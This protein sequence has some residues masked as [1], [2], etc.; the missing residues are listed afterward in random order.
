[1]GILYF[2]VVQVFEGTSKAQQQIKVKGL[3]VAG[4]DARQRWLGRLSRTLVSLA[5]LLQG[6]DGIRCFT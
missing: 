4:N 2:R 1:M 3:V 5:G 6:G